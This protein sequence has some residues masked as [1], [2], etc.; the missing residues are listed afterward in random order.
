MIYS[1][2]FLRH[3]NSKISKNSLFLESVEIKLFKIAL[4]R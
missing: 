4:L 3:Q 1:K 2:G